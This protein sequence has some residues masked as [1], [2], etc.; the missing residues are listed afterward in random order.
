[1]FSVGY[2]CST[3]VSIAGAARGP[4]M[5][6]LAGVL[7][8]GLSSPLEH[9]TAGSACAM[10]SRVNPLRP[11]VIEGAAE[12]RYCASVAAR[13]CT[14]AGEPPAGSGPSRSP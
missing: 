9:V 6:E 5:S 3:S 12:R 1:M 10:Q 7:Q 13:D 14:L 2:R 8:E 11:A 4:S